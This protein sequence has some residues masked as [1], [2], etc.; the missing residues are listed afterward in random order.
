MPL[1]SNKLILASRSPR[2]SELLHSLG[3]EFEVSPSNVDEI[4]HPEQSPEQNATNIARD[5]AR[6]VARQ[7]P[8]SYVL[9][10][11]TMVVLDQEIIGQPTD[12]EDA[13]RILSKLAGK[14]HRVITGVVLI[15]PEAEEYATATVSTVSIKSVTENEIRSYVATGEPLDKAG[16]YAIQGEGSFLVESWEGSYS[17]IVGLPLEALTDLFQQAGFPVP[18]KNEDNRK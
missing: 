12:E 1:S 16:A 11:D 14:Q 17:N 13:C 5:K 2:R 9:G 7:N 10:A 15:S 6:W 3:L 8:G 18:K 4:T